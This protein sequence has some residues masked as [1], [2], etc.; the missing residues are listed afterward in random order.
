MFFPL[1]YYDLS[2]WLAAVAIIL[3]ITSEIICSSTEYSSRV[4]IDKNFLR[5]VSL[6]CGLAFVGMFIMHVANYF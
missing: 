3:L 1:S 2:L 4:V 6:G 5:A